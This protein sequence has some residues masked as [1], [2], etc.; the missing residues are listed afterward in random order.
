MLYEQEA[1]G[2]VPYGTESSK[3][4]GRISLRDGVEPQIGNPN[5]CLNVGIF[6]G[7]GMP[8]VKRLDHTGL[9]C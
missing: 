7:G 1:R 5:W 8:G 6:T 4:P 3:R 9:L 2:V